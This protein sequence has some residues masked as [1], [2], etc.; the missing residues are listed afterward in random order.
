MVP[1]WRN[2]A[3]LRRSA[4]VSEQMG[5]LFRKPEQSTRHDAQT[6]HIPEECVPT[7]PPSPVTPP[8]TPCHCAV[9][10][11]SVGG[12]SAFRGFRCPLVGGGAPRSPMCRAPCSCRRP[13]SGVLNATATVSDIV[14]NVRLASGMHVMCPELLVPSSISTSP[15]PS[16]PTMSTPIPIP[17]ENDEDEHQHFNSANLHTAI[18]TLQSALVR[19]TPS[20]M[21]PLHAMR[22]LLCSL[23]IPNISLPISWNGRWTVRPAAKILERARIMSNAKRRTRTEPPPTRNQSADFNANPPSQCPF[24][25]SPSSFC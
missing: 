10:Q 24:P 18:C 25:S 6:T 5:R 12:R 4:H 2:G 15:Y 8:H 7:R 3:F 22:P 20:A 14:H 11:L 21:Q 1:A 17:I 9:L 23:Y 19:H 13:G 16:I